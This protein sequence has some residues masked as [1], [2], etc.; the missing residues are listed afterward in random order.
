MF[1]DVRYALRILGKTPGFLAAAVFSIALAIGAGTTMFSAFRAV[2]LKP[3]PYRDADRL[4]T[5]SKTGG[6]HRD[7][8]VTYADVRFW[9]EHARTIESSG[10]CGGFR[11]E[12]LTGVREPA[13][14]VVRF[15]SDSV[16]QTLESPAL[17]GRTLAARD[18]ESG[19]PRAAVISWSTWQKQFG[20]DQKIIGREILLDGHGFAVVGVMPEGFNYPS[21][22]SSAWIPDETV[23]TDPLDGG[24]NIIARLRPGVTIERATAEIARLRP[25]LALAYPPD[26]RNWRIELDEFST[27][28]TRE[29]R[30]AFLLLF[31]AV[32]LLMLIGCLNV[33]NLLLARSSAREAEFAT[34]SALGA[35]RGRLIRQVLT[36]SLVLAMAGG[37]AG[38]LLAWGGA[39]LISAT[40][41]AAPG[42]DKTRVDF[43]VMWFAL[44][45]TVATGLAFGIA[46]AL[47]LPRL[48]LR[49]SARTVTDSRAKMRRR[50][51]LMVSE[52]GLSLLLLVGAGLLLRSFLRLTEVNPG[53]RA[54]HV[55]TAWIPTG[56]RAAMDKNAVTRRYE[57][58]VEMAQNL[59]GVTA[60]GLASALQMGHVNV[61]L[62]FCRPG[63][64]TEQLTN[65]R[66]VSHDYFRAMGIPLKRG[67]AL[68]DID[69]KGGPGVALVNE[70]FARRYWPGENPVGQIIEA[71]C[72]SKSEHGVTVVGV[73]GDTLSSD[74]SAPPEPEEYMSYRQ[75]MGPV[76]GV[77]LVVRT[78]GDPALLAT[79][80]RTGIHGL[81]PDQVITEISTMRAMVAETLARPRFYMSL[82]AGFAA[83][84]L[85]LT[86][87]GIYGVISYAVGQR[88]REMGIRIALGAQAMD[89]LRAAAI[90]GLRAIV[91]GLGAGLV[92][93]W[94][95][96]RFLRGLVF[97]I[98]VLDPVTFVLAAALLAAAGLAACWLPARRATRI[99]PNTALR[100]D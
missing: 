87:I 49:Q 79:A 41:P 50:T 95:L 18:F 59:P 88:T 86:L 7:R 63:D 97:G 44:A 64:T 30:K 12:T 16:F 4:V 5:I 53:F 40:I 77:T 45:V 68:A 26:R 66:A 92:A 25:A 19:A 58:I 15:V 36:E 24:G 81:Y 65:F 94:A 13:N 56:G 57:R 33:A 54:E 23:I 55:L 37:V 38:L 69:P 62:E 34:R 32:G 22:G 82:V 51:L 1:D 67:R 21:P 84:A 83:L 61:A 98:T 71:D 43:S 28:E 90:D 72:S 10:T 9:R 31:G 2:F 8:Q 46:P 73:V 3:L 100:Q 42:L 75:Y 48:A 29:Y 93:A 78:A 6:D 60:A 17:M 76:V 89:V 47:E 35:G 11:M 70:T 20:G 80:L 99:D 39:H 52:I 27:A 14:L 96:T 85:L 91:W 74:L